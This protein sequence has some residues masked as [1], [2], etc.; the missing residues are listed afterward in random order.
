MNLSSDSGSSY[1]NTMDP[2]TM[3]ACKHMLSLAGHVIE[4]VLTL[5]QWML[6]CFCTV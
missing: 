1:D 3:L 2:G 6:F 4:T 5:V